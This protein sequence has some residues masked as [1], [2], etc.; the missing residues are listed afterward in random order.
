MIDEDGREFRKQ[1]EEQLE[2]RAAPERRARFLGLL[3]RYL[4]DDRPA[5]LVGGGLVEI[6]TQGQYVTGD[7][8]IVADSERVG[9]LLEAAGFQ[10]RGRHFVEEELGLTVEIVAPHLDPSQE[11]ERLR[12]GE[13]TLTILSLEDLIVDRLAAATFWETSTD[14]EQAQIV[15]GAHRDR[16][17]DDRLQQRAEEEQVE[18]LLTE[19]RTAEPDG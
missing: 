11:S 12:R 8:D 19:L 1:L 2:G 7:L 17:D 10:R 16:I 15:Y 5:V 9:S 6:L 3:N 14:L 13:Y 4:P 18:D